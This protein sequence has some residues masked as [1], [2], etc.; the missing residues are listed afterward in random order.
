LIETLQPHRDGSGGLFIGT[1]KLLL[2]L[3]NS[4]PA[5]LLH[6]L[7]Y[8]ALQPYRLLRPD[9]RGR[10]P[11][12]SGSASRQT[13]K[14]AGGYASVGI[15]FPHTMRFCKEKAASPDIVGL[16]G[17]IRAERFGLFIKLGDRLSVFIVSIRTGF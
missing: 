6:P 11:H 10:R 8:A 7:S 4:A 14:N 12:S 13:K 9:R 16:S 15:S 1:S 17:S 2:A 5:E 3:M